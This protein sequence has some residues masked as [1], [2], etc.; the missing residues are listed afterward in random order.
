[1]LTLVV[2]DVGGKQRVPRHAVLVILAWAADE[3]LLRVVD[4][5]DLS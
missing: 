2:T 5:V 3:V 4:N 1:L